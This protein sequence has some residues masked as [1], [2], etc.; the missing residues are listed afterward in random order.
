MQYISNSNLKLT[1][2]HWCSHLSNNSKVLRVGC[3]LLLLRLDNCGYNYKVV[4]TIDS[5]M[6][7]C[8][9]LIFIAV[10]IYF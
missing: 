3:L 5:V 2:S 6:I 1:Q 4:V 8:Y 7:L 9:Y 10:I